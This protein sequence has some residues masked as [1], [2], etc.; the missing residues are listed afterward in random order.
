MVARFRRRTFMPDSPTLP[1]AGAAGSWNL[2]PLATADGTVRAQI[3]D[4]Q[5]LFDADVTVPIAQGKIDFNDATVEH[6]G[7]DSRMGVG[8]Q[9]V[10]V[11]AVNG[12]TYLYEFPSSPPAGVTFESRGALLG[13]WVSDRG[14]LQLQAFVEALLR[15]AGGQAPG[16]TEP[17]RALLVRTALQGEIKLGDGQFTGPGIQAVLAGS[18]EGR[19]VVRFHSEAASRGVTV[20]IGSLLV[21]NAVI[22][23]GTVQLHCDEITGAL[24]LRLVVEDANVRFALD[25]SKASL[26]GLRAG[27]AP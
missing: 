9:G 15:P 21:R 20:E 23:S 8:P 26:S 1:Q 18:A 12:R 6:V 13:P 24:E 22:D 11:D 17:A 19:N 14:S 3:V 2:G 10:Y 7:P 16:P 27:R 25:F 4:A 5:L